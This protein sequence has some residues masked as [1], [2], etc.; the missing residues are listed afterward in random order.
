VGAINNAN[1]GVKA[2]VVNAGTAAAPA[3]KLTLTSNATGTANDIVIVNDPTALAIT[4]TQAA[5]DAMFSISGLG[6]FTRSTNS[7]SDV[8]DGV[9]ITLKAASGSTD[10]TLD[11]DK[12]S[13]Q[14]KVQSLLDAYND[15]VRTIDGQTI[16]QQKSDG[17]V[18]GGAFSGDATPRLIRTSLATVIA[19]KIGGGAYSRLA[20]IGITTQ[21]D[22]T[23][24]LDDT[25][26]Q[27]ALA[28][29]PASVATLFG[30]TSTSDGLADLL[31]TAV[32]TQT[33]AV[34]GMIAV[35]Q[36]GLTSTI[37]DVQNQI[38][39]ATDRLGAEETRLREQFS[40]LELLVSN[41]Q[42]SGNAM[43]QALNSLNN[44]SSNNK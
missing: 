1:A 18:S 4:N 35:R 2:T 38:D 11:Y 43:L 3:Y 12:S 23:L 31:S 9:T 8:I 39:Q 42:R 40:N 22:G 25:K 14:S 6:S 19:S 29:D 10:L 26:F 36:D 37:K 33:K 30:G 16:G 24:S 5:A 27:N 17:S 7:V 13:T 34:T 20:D 44:L 32:D 21:K 28:S 15:V 41:A